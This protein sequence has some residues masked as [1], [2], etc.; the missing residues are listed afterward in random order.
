[1]DKVQLSVTYSFDKQSM[2]S[3]PVSEPLDFFR[4]HVIVEEHVL[5]AVHYLVENNNN[6]YIYY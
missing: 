3:I 6:N 5:I 1:M 4:K 2:G